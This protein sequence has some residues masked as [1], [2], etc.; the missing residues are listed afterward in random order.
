MLRNDHLYLKCS[1]K[2]LR[3]LQLVPLYFSLAELVLYEFEER[4]LAWTY[5][6]ELLQVLVQVLLYKFLV[7]RA[8]NLQVKDLRKN[9]IKNQ[10]KVAVSI[11]TYSQQ[12]IKG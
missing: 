4:P 8:C 11:P 12:A 10:S 1:S 2:T 7:N 9:Y 5:Q 3:E 6:I